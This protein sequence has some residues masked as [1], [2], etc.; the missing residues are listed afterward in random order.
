M[1][2]SIL[3][4]SFMALLYAVS[5]FGQDAGKVEMKGMSPTIKQ[6]SVVSG[7]L[8]EL[9]GKYK[10]R[11]TELTVEP[12]GYV[13]EHHHRG[14]GMRVI[15]SGHMSYVLPD[16]T[17]VYGVGDSFYESGDV[18]H[19]MQNKGSSPLQFLLF[20]ILPVDLQGSSLMPPK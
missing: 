16:K 7:Y 9:N 13:K 20:E 6:E 11:V 18:T 10:L 19:S 14:P 17:I 4:F 12:G 8:T 15:I 2:R 1:G 3:S 5:V